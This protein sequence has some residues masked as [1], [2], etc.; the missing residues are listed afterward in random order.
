MASTFAAR[1]KTQAYYQ[2]GVKSLLA[3]NKLAEEPLDEITSEKIAGFIAK[4]RQDGLQIASINREL[5][6]LRRMFHL[7][8]EWG[9]LERVPARVRMIPGERRRER[10]L[11]WAEEKRYLEEAPPLLHD[12]ATI[13]IDCGLRPEECFRLKWEACATARLKSSMARRTTRGG[14][15]QCLSALPR[16]WK[17][18]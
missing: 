3:Y 1:S 15:S 4:R 9:K 2:Y 12:V 18:A 14:E 5:Q 8:Q 7:A 17:C 6:V 13:L 11:S 10:V 16:C